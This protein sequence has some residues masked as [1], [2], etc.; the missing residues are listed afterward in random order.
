MS[1]SSPCTDGPPYGKPREDIASSIQRGEREAYTLQARYYFDVL[2]A[3]PPILPLES[4]SSYSTRLAQA[5]GIRI[6]QNLVGL[7]FPL[8]SPNQTRRLNDCPPL[9]LETLEAL[10]GCPTPLLLA[11][12]FYP[13]GPLF[14]RH[15]HPQ[16]LAKF[17]SGAVAPSLRYCPACLSEDADPYY[18]LTWRF[19]LLRGCPKHRCGL[20]DLCWRCAQPLP[21]I[22]TPIRM[23][24]CPACGA[25]LRE[26]KAL[27]LQDGEVA[28]VEHRAAN[29]EFALTARQAEAPSDA[30]NWAALATS[31]SAHTAERLAY[32]RAI[33]ERC[34]TLRNN[35]GMSREEISARAGVSDKV[36]RSIERGSI[37]NHGASFLQW[38]A[39]ADALGEA[40]RQILDPTQ[41][42]LP[43]ETEQGEP[44]RLHHHSSPRIAATKQRNPPPPA[45][46]LLPSAPR[47]AGGRRTRDDTAI[48]GRVRRAI[49]AVRGEGRLITRA[50]VAREVGLTKAALYHYPQVRALLDA[51]IPTSADAL[52]ARAAKR[53]QELL[54][55]VQ[56]AASALAAAGKRVNCK[57]IFREMGRSRSGLMRYPAVKAFLAQVDRTPPGMSAEQRAARESELL[58]AVQDSAIQL[59]AE[60][61]LVSSAAISRRMGVSVACLRG[62]PQVAQTLSVLAAGNGRRGKRRPV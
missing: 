25:D 45:D 16:T 59:R 49:D 6:L 56:D 46:R 7:Y 5:N 53:E 55:A 48:Y 20:A 50:E 58:A 22:N 13:L 19:T 8:Q 27:P 39:Y 30:A 1:D 11:T 4:L 40:L 21:L 33:G 42:P 10:S 62:Y 24:E 28:A 32:G 3:R 54:Q 34:V 41:T 38:V 29:L 51:E 57:A 61:H 37:Q 52:S 23:A 26:A 35:R 44:K 15:V 47:L 31:S 9:R 18:R 2:P 60:G 43:V 12:T 36:V 17:L 14:G